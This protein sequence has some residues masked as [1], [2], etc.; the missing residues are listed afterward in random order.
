LTQFLLVESQAI[1][2]IAGAR[3]KDAV[4]TRLFRDHFTTQL[5]VIGE[6]V[7]ADDIDLA[8]PWTSALR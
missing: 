5:A 6:F 2:V 4:K 3:A 1:R 7:I 8:E